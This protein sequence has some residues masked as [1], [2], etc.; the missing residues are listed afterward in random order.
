MI[1][2]TLLAATLFS[3]ATLSAKEFTIAT[4][5]PLHSMQ[6]ELAVKGRNGILI[7]QKLSFGSYHTAQVKRS[8]IR[9]WTG[10][11]GFPGTI[12]TEHMDGRQ[13]I[14]FRLTNGTDTS[15]AMSVTHV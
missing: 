2:N 9:K 5:E 13:S 12:W 6:Q 11:T 4:G 10:I 15:D 14:R 8:A 3:A 7:K 1:K